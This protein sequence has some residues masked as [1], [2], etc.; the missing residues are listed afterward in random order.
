MKQLHASLWIATL[1]I[2]TIIF[3]RCTPKSGDPGPKGEPGS[4]G[5]Q[6]SQGSAGPVGPAGSTGPAGTANVQYS[7]WTTVNFVDNGGG[8]YGANITAIAIT[9]DIIDKADIRVYWKVGSTIISIPY[10]FTDRYGIATITP[11]FQVGKIY[12]TASYPPGNQQQFRYVIIPGGTAVGGRKAAVDYRNYETVRQ[13]FN[14][15]D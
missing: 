3:Q 1:F 12:L 14:L 9:Q 15:P 7:P 2:S 10:T 4:A 8:S 5:Q 6:G 13:A 11:V